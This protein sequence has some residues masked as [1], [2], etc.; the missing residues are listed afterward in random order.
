[1]LDDLKVLHTRDPHDALGMLERHWRS[2]LP[3]FDT[4]AI[5]L[6][7][8]GIGQVV[9]G[10]IGDT[11][12]AGQV[13]RAATSIAVPFEIVDAEVL[14]SYVNRRTVYIA[15]SVIGLHDGIAGAMA[16]EAAARGAYV[17]VI[18]PKGALQDFA[19][20]QGY[21]SVL[22]PAAAWSPQ[23]YLPML[24][25]LIAVLSHLQVLPDITREMV[26]AAAREVSPALDA[27]RAT[28]PVRKNQAKQL[29]LE[30]MGRSLV[31]SSGPGL[32]PAAQQWKRRVN[33]N[34]KQLAWVERARLDD[35]EAI[36]WTKQLVDKPYAVVELQST[37]ESLCIQRHFEVTERFLSGMRP[38]P[39]VVSV[40]GHT[41]L[42]QILW[43]S[44]L[45]DF[46]SVYTA[47]VSGVQPTISRFNEVYKQA[48][49]KKI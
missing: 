34:A 25:A 3:V 37:L 47:I 5:Q 28:I 4:A 18:A 23:Q 35:G 44:M 30:I 33:Q 6:P 41:L 15:A 21:A 9:Y 16:A 19:K 12:I 29:A 39:L 27:W 43:A 31:I 38:H 42:A 36:A 13:L 22:L 17:V 24:G 11:A 14:P 8:D 49:E 46:V 32:S 1:M 7:T 26:Q 2:T 10:A 40:I 45:G 20:A 48:M